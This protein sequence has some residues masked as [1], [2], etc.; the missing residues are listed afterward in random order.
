MK[1]AVKRIV[2][3]MTLAGMLLG[4]VICGQADAAKKQEKDNVAPRGF[5][6]LFNGKDFTGWKAR[7]RGVDT[8]AE[9][10]KWQQNWK[11]EAGLIKF[12][13][14]GPTLWT[15]RKFKDFV[16]MVDWRFPKPGDSGIYLRGRSKNQVNIWCNE[17]G[18]GE[19]WGYRTDKK[20]PG[21]IRKACTPLK[22]MDKPVGQWNRFVITM[23]GDRLTVK[24]NGE[25]V[26]KSA[27]LPGV[28]AE[29]EIALQRHGNPIDFKNIYVKSLDSIPKPTDDL[30][31]GTDSRVQAVIDELE[32][33]CIKRKIRLLAP[34]KAQRLRELL[35]QAKPRTVVEC[36]TAVGYASLWIA[37]ELKA[38]DRGKLTTIEI[39]PS[40]AREAEANIRK[41]GLA[42]YV[43]VRV[44]DARKLVKE[45]K[46]P[47]D[48][49]LLDCLPQNYYAC[50][51]GLED[52]LEDGA[53][54]VADNAGY[55]ARGMANYLK[56]VRAK[57]KS[58]TEWFD[59][60]LPWAKRDALEVTVVRRSEE[61]QK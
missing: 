11:V 60:D 14:K 19:V 57:Y 24:L 58:T 34:E 55:G 48:L 12:D 20:L 8:E 53:I 41:A 47:I 13:G 5:R 27:Q 40:L 17:M 28:P 3:V 38:A 30:P 56:H 15:A 50:F 16:L 2:V 39:V 22:K 23:K 52:R 35:R 37:R 36:G 31:A 29:G 44:G 59:I 6:V 42:D 26:I 49:V 54:V 25:I 33:T 43:T 10:A 51:I 32:K 1:M 4:A 45:L 9:R 21:E 7:Q 18:S 61:R 46:G